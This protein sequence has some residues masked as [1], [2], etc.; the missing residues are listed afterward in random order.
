MK[1][2][3][4][5]AS[6]A[7]MPL[8]ATL[9]SA[10]TVIA[11]DSDSDAVLAG[12]SAASGE[13]RLQYRAEESGKPAVSVSL[14]IAPDYHYVNN[15][16]GLAIHDYTLR[17]IFWVQP[18]GAYINNSLYADVWYRASELKNR[19]MLGGALKKAGTEAAKVPGTTDPFWV[20]SA[21]GM[22]SPDL[23]RRDLKRSDEKLGARWMLDGEQVAAVRYDKDAVPEAVKPGLK[24]FWRTVI[25]VH[26]D[27]ADALAASGHMPAELWFKQIKLGAERIDIHWTLISQHWERAAT[28]PLAA[29][30][31]ATPS[32][33]AG[34]FPAI[35]ATLSKEVANHATPPQADI[36]E[37]RARDALGRHAGLEAMLWVMEMNLAE[38]TPVSACQ[39]TDLR[40][41]CALS[42]QAGPDVRA[43]SRTAIAFTKQ[44]PDEADRAQFATLP[45]AYLLRLL[46][47]TRPPGKGVE[48]KEVE[49]DLLAA[50]QAS[51]VANFSKDTGDF[52]AMAWQPFAAWQV[53]DLGRLMAGHRA[54]DLLG[55]IDTLEASLATQESV[56]F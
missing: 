11:P 10:A 13:L 9:G 45:N 22:V 47:A 17:R 33:A 34:A 43:D 41:Y 8:I 28:Y 53:W 49:H 39:P 37:A 35:F 7:A 18:T 51:P 26:P 2:A 55:S 56:F 44:A 5:W 31:T 27:I 40:S 36:Y 15:E 6:I 42:E 46:W 30:L 38:G 3:L 32:V 54:G 24:R 48:R 12:R 23:P 16:Y 29:H 52:Y 20:E 25:R 50:L 19:V 1:Q 14:G 21:L 4:S